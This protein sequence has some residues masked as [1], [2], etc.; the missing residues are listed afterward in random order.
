MV[1]VKAVFSFFIFFKNKNYKNIPSLGE[2]T[3][4]YPC[5]PM[6]G[7]FGAYREPV[8][9]RWGDRIG[10][11]RLTQE[12]HETTAP[13]KLEAACS[14]IQCGQNPPPQT[15]GRKREEGVVPAKPCWNR[16]AGSLGRC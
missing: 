2:F 7:R 11:G 3:G 8:A 16:I 10:P 4:L 14:P 1:H 9:R 13:I 5:C 15:G 12:R 6:V